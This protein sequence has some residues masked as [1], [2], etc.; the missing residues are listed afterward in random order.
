MPG[1]SP[2]LLHLKYTFV[3]REILILTAVVWELGADRP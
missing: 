1:R 3:V 2:G